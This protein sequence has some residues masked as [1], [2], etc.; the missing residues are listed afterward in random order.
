[1]PQAY[2]ILLHEQKKKDAVLERATKEREQEKD[3][4][5]EEKLKRAEEIRLKVSVR[6]SPIQNLNNVS[7]SSFHSSFVAG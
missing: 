4:Q 1:L 2:Q 7:P 6:F 5:R 3:R